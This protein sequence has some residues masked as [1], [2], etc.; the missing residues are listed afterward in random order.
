MGNGQKM[1]PEALDKFGL[2]LVLVVY[3]VDLFVHVTLT[4]YF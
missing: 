3:A 1:K 2:T 4:C